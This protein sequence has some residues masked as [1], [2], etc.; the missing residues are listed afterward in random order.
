MD[1]RSFVANKEER[2]FAR[3][4]RREYDKGQLL[5]LAGDNP[6]NIFYLVSGIVRV[7]DISERGS[8]IVVSVYKAPTFFPVP[9]L[10]FKQP[11]KFFFEAATRVVSREAPR[12]RTLKFIRQNADVMYDMLVEVSVGVEL[13][14]RRIAHFMGGNAR[15]RLLFEL[16]NT[17]RLFG[18]SLPDGSFWI[19]VSEGE[20]GARSGLSRETVS[21][22]IHEL[23][24]MNL[25]SIRPQGIQLKDLDALE[26]ALGSTL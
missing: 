1:N 26:A 15:S 23:K 10:I 18:E 21:R 9:W 11:N 8:E 14:R 7:Y 16:I 4:P 2:F 5:L 24:K 22:E 17:T 3:F 13:M 6:K 25:I 12:D 20:I 19:D